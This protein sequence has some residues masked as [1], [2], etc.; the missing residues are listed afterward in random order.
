MLAARKDKPACDWMEDNRKTGMD[1]QV[2]KTGV[3]KLRMFEEV[4]S[5]NG[6]MKKRNERMKGSIYS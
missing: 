2:I 1:S 5:K 4:L 3:L 6:N